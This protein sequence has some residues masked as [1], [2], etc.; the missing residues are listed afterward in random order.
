MYNNVNHQERVKL[1]NWAS[2]PYRIKGNIF[3]TKNLQKNKMSNLWKI[4]KYF[5]KT[6]TFFY[7]SSKID[8]GRK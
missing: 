8:L 4:K 5:K 2:K 3:F 7:S 1:P 6:F